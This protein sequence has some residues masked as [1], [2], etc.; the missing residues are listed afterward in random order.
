MGVSTRSEEKPVLHIAMVG[1]VD[2]GKSTLIG[3]IRHELSALPGTAAVDASIGG[4]WAYVV[5]QLREEREREMTIDTTQ[6]FLE[7]PALRLIFIDVPGHQ[8]LIQ[9]MLS[10]ATR[11]DAA[12]LVLAADEGVRVQT[13]R[14]AL[15]LSMLGIRNVIVAVNKMDLA[16]RSESAF[17]ALEKSILAELGELGIAASATIPVVARDGDNVVGGSTAMAW[18]TGPSVVEA[19]GDVEPAAAA[20]DGVRF[21]V[22]DV[23][24]HD[25]PT[26]VG[27]VLSGVIAQGDELAV[28]PT[29]AT[30]KVTGVRRFP[31][32][33]APA[34]S[35]E[36]VGLLV[37]GG[38]PG[39]GDVLASPTDMPR[40]SPEVVGRVF[41]LAEEPLTVGEELALRCATQCVNVRVAE[42]A[43]A[44]DTATL[45]PLPATGR[46]AR[47]ELATVTLSAAKPVVVER[48]ERL[49]GL[50]RFVLERGGVPTGF[51]IVP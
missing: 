49:P 5:D 44:L 32:N 13:R 14:H 27:R 37:D 20:F 8:E 43:D 6:T 34:E 2:H 35:G 48:F 15:L 22:Q 41:W 9:N 40:S 28:C 51:G 1:H 3:R 7:T 39:R 36:S 42:V 19:L 17:H 11:A 23:Y 31:D 18:Y 10:G 45:D 12:V 26:V 33:R 50:G 29:G 25:T 30:V 21:P 38:L 4:N 46:L 47:M 24:R 16:E